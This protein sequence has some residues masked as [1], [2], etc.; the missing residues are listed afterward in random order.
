MTTATLPKLV[1]MKFNLETTPDKFGVMEDS[2]HLIGNPKALQDKI[3]EDGY[4]YLK[5]V[6]D[7]QNVL[8]ARE[9]VCRRLESEG[10][11]QPGWTETEATCVE[12]KV[13]G[14][15]PHY[16]ENNPA[17]DQVVFGKPI[18]DFYKNLVGP[19]VR[20][21]DY[22]WFR[23]C[24]TG[25]N[26]APPHCD[27]VYMGRGTHNVYTAWIP[28]GPISFQMGPLM[29][30]ENSYKNRHRIQNY[31]SRDVDTY[32]TNYSDGDDIKTGKK[33]WHWEGWLSNN[34]YSLREKLGGRWMA[35]EFQPGDFLTFTIETIHA[36]LDNQTPHIR[37]TSDT[38]YQ[39]AHESIDERWIGEKPPA[40]GLA[41][42]RGKIC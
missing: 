7:R 24:S 18:I 33:M 22:K 10:F 14:W 13:I 23:P 9:E 11:I 40:H 21:Y 2:S 35:A 12:D 36:F 5:G 6:L 42:K 28:Y 27:V 38:R 3:H 32:C 1:A 16:T 30:L 41:G 8:D 26:G 25:V 4:L 37:I 20:H 19:D 29:M 15:A 39:S 31:L 34:P 17:L